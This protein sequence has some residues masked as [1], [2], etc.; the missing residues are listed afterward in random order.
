LEAVDCALGTLFEVFALE[1]L[2]AF[3]WLVFNALSGS[4]LLFLS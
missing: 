3:T 2:A 4:F 1:E